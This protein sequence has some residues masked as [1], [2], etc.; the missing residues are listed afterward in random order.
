[1]A[2]NYESE[3]TQFLK[4]YKADHPDTEAPAAFALTRLGVGVICLVFFQKLGNFGFVVFCHN[5]YV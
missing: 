4:K 2:K 3:I 5:V 1:M